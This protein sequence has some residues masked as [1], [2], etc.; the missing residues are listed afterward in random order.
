MP[1]AYVSPLQVAKQQVAKEAAAMDAA[2]TA[3]T[4]QLASSMSS[5][6]SSTQQ[7]EGN[8]EQQVAADTAASAEWDAG[9]GKVKDQ[10]QSELLP[11]VICLLAA[12]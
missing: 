9:L 6:T 5:L 3:A 4:E 10:M 7:L 2:R 1:T 11:G 12:E 8:L